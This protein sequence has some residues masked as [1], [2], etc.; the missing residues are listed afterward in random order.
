MEC[1]KLA[2]SERE[3]EREWERQCGPNYPATPVSHSPH[4][5]Q[6]NLG[7]NHQMCLKRHELPDTCYPCNPPPTSTLEA[8]WTNTAPS[9]TMQQVEC[10][11]IVDQIQ[12]IFILIFRQISIPIA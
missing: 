9:L 11:S 7:P 2:Y 10:Y 3:R 5:Q 1:I 6:S 12:Y 4:H 8:L